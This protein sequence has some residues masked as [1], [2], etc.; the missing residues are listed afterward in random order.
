MR[1]PPAWLAGFRGGFVALLPLWA[2]ALPVGVAYA[3]A[4]HGAGLGFAATQA[5][6]LTLFSAAAQV[7]VASSLR[8]GAPAALIVATALALNAQL[9]LYGLALGRQLRPAWAACLAGAWLLTDGAYGVTMAEGRPS[10]ARLLGAGSSMY[11]AW[12]AGTLL[13]GVAGRT[14]PDVRRLGIDFVVPLTFL[15][16]LMPLLRT[17]TSLLTAAVAAGVMPAAIHAVPSGA[18]VLAAGVAG[19]LIGSLL[20]DGG[21]GLR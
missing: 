8:A 17:R 11:V 10:V 15:A 13:G 21:R 5:L 6:S 18:A 4:A 1:R 14:L 12:N 9:V 16:V 7:S 2:G 20:P 3:V 19:S